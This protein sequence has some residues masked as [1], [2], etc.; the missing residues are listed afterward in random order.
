MTTETRISR[1]KSSA[2]RSTEQTRFPRPP[3]ALW[4]VRSLY[5]SQAALMGSAVLEQPRPGVW[6][7]ASHVQF[8]HLGRMWLEASDEPRV[9]TLGRHDLV[10]LALPLDDALSLRHVLFVVRSAGRGVRFTVMDLQTPNGLHLFERGA[11]RLVEATGPVIVRA[12]EFILFCVPTGAGA[13]LPRRWVELP[14]MV[15]A[16]VE[17]GASAPSFQR[18]AGTLELETATWKRTHT[19]TQTELAR[20]VQI[21]RQDRCELCV[22]DLTVSRVHGVLLQLDGEPY[23]ADAGST[24][25]LWVK[26]ELRSVIPLRDDVSVWFGG[27]L[28]ARWVRS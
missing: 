19:L 27:E 10:D 4:S 1:V 3:T 25:G 21:G 14:P 13:R 17:A 23:L 5:E 7:F 22:T 8:G 18:I 24:N 12:S 28:S 6:V 2:P 16:R 20:G 15:P 26:G 9:G 11:V